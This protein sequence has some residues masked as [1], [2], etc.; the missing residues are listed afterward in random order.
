MPLNLSDL[1][2]KTKSISFEFDNE[3]VTMEVR[4][5]S[6]TPKMIANLKATQTDD[7]AV[8]SL[9]V[10]LVARWDVM[11]GTSPFPLDVDKLSGI[12]MIFQQRCLTEIFASVGEDMGLVK[13]DTVGQFALYLAFNGNTGELPDYYLT[14]KAARYLGV[15]PWELMEQ[16]K[17][18]QDAALICESAEAK[19]VE[20]RR[21][22]DAPK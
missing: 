9:L 18:W 17:G 10:Q 4:V 13:Y 3:A 22:L 12:S 14:V 6:I 21:K 19:A 16:F 1:V 2:T 7:N 15:A 20:I 5:Q 11:D 8:S